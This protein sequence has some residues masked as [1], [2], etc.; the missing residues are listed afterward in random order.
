MHFLQWN[1]TLVCACIFVP[2]YMRYPHQNIITMYFKSCMS[3]HMTVTWYYVITVDLCEVLL[4]PPCTCYFFT[5]PCNMRE[6]VSV[7]WGPSALWHKCMQRPHPL[8][9]SQ[10]VSVIL[11]LKTLMTTKL[12]QRKYDFMIL[13]LLTR[14][15][16]CK[17]SFCCVAAECVYW[18]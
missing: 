4:L 16:C 11:Y 14:M 6:A 17:E 2:A 18:C 9:D 5:W 3:A 15:G 1:S 7:G 12:T 8:L 13:F 10:N